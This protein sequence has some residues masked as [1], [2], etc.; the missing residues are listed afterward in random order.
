MVVLAT[1]AVGGKRKR[2]NLRVQKRM[3]MKIMMPFIKRPF[4]GGK[5]QWMVGMIHHGSD[6][7][8]SGQIVSSSIRPHSF[9]SACCL[10]DGG[11][12]GLL[13]LLLLLFHCQH[14]LKRHGCLKFHRCATGG[15][16]GLTSLHHAVSAVG[17]STNKPTNCE[18][19]DENANN[20]SS[21]SCWWR[22]LASLK[23][24]HLPS[25][26]RWQDV[27]VSKC[28]LRNVRG[29]QIQADLLRNL[30]QKNRIPLGQF[31]GQ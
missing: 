1:L 16:H 27:E 28:S 14:A 30:P 23:I 7:E 24:T 29:R 10:R 8:Y 20:E 13:L 25:F 2:F 12:Q 21:M 11:G 19:V 17:N 3:T 31:H 9:L 18:E 26:L 6:F 15:S 22:L 4:D 5:S